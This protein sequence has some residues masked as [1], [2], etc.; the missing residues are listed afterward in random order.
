MK[1]TLL[2]SLVLVAA[3]LFVDAAHAQRRGDGPGRGP[4]GPGHGGPGYSDGR[5][6]GRGPGYGPGRGPGRGPG[7]DDPGYGGG[8]GP[9]RPAPR[10]PGPPPHRPPPP[11]P[12]RY[13]QWVYCARDGE[14][15]RVPGFAQVRFGAYGRYNYM[16]V[17][18]YVFCDTRTF[19]NPI[20]GYPKVCEY[21]AR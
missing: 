16:N 4:G 1:K 12:P 18:G 9:G 17:N 3:M 2:T 10:P 21:L 20:N 6:D 7:Y 13:E 19:G 15:C 8:R 11:P 5:G 14:V